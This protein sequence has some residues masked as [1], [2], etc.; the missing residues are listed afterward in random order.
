MVRVTLRPI[1][2][3]DA[4]IC[5]RWVSDPDVLRYLG[6]VQPAQ[7]LEKERAWI[8]S[9]L[10]DKTHQR[11]FVI[12]DEQK[13]PIGTCGLRGIDR[14]AGIAFLGIMVGEKHLW[15]RGYGTAATR[16]LLAVAFDELGLQEV[17]LSCHAENRGAIRCYEKAGFRPSPHRARRPQFGRHEVCMAIRREEWKQPRQATEIPE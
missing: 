12:E 11:V 13:Q 4:E 2:M 15:N 5:F 6:L 14:D 7:T 17:H 8:A 16:A 3:T 10:A 9:I 1:R